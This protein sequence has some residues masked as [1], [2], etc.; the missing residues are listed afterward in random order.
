MLR[1][2]VDLEVRPE[3]AQLGGDGDVALGV[4]R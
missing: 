3:L 2:P 1:E 4:T